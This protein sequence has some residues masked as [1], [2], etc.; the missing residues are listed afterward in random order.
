[1]RLGSDLP[2]QTLRLG[3]SRCR[4]LPLPILQLSFPV[5]NTGKR[6]LVKRFSK[7]GSLGFL[8]SLLCDMRLL[9]RGHALLA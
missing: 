1:M 2:K 4:L 7:Y 6:L 5:F 8:S 9:L 3:K